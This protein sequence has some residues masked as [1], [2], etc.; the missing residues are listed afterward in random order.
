MK[1]TRARLRDL[2][3]SHGLLIALLAGAILTLSFNGQISGLLASATSSL[4]EH[5]ATV[6][7]VPYGERDI[8]VGDVADIDVNLNAREPVNAIGA[9]IIFP[10]EQFEIVG[11]SKRRSFLDLWTEE[12]VIRESA[13]S[14]RFSGGTTRPGGMTG[15]STVITLSVRAKKPGAAQL[16]ITDL[17]VLA[18]D[19]K[20]TALDTNARSLSY[21]I[22]YPSSG[23]STP[24]TPSIEPGPAAPSA[25]FD[26]SGRVTLVDI[27][28]LTVRLVLPYD[29]RYDLDTN[30]SINLA[31]ISIAFSQMKN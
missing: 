3:T 11:I 23:G 31:D 8:A 28:I 20:G 25:D 1:K 14:I 18:H 19:G 17:Q 15:T 27:S 2:L 10:P 12:T 26:G 13:G 7:F 5:P 16:S 6:Y 22:A 4:S 29:T 9:T 30:G 21:D 24:V